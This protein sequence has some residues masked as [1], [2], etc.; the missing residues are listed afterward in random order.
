[1]WTICF[2]LVLCD[3]AKIYNMIHLSSYWN[4]LY[5]FKDLLRAME[6]ISAIFL[7][8]WNKDTIWQLVECCILHQLLSK[9][10]LTNFKRNEIL[11]SLISFQNR[12]VTFTN[13]LYKSFK[14]SMYEFCIQS[15]FYSDQRLFDR[16]AFRPEFSCKPWY[17]TT[18]NLIIHS[19]SGVLYIFFYLCRLYK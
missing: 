12:K 6:V 4:K 18:E 11:S 9:D 14:S 5:T 16:H 3:C 7:F 15:E 17:F 13:N 8:T 1:M 19:S 10:Y 2:L